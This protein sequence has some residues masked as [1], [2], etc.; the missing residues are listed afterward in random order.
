MKRLI[1][2]SIL[3]LATATFP[4]GAAND[5]VKKPAAANTSSASANSLDPTKGRFHQ[6]HVKKLKMDCTGCHSPETKD[7][8][9]LRRD[10]ALP[11]GMPGQV[12][13]TVCL[14][15]HQEPAKP[16]WYKAAAH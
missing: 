15:C 10:K 13:R 2:F 8:L 1:A 4:A 12:D 9:F 11:A 7:D 3:V 14:S 6:R 16:S 5:A